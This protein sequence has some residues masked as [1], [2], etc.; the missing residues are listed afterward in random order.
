MPSSREIT[1]HP[2]FLRVFY[3]FLAFYPIFVYKY[4]QREYSTYDRK[5]CPNGI[6]SL[7]MHKHFIKEELICLI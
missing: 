5:S 6:F 7:F 2:P 3:F 4:K 1:W